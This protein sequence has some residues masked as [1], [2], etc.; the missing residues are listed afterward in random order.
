MT[1]PALLAKN[2]P[3]LQDRCEVKDQDIHLIRIELSVSMFQK[4]PKLPTRA[5]PNHAVTNAPQMLPHELAA[6]RLVALSASL[7]VQ[8]MRV[9]GSSNSANVTAW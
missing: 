6:M 4:G 8:L 9:I 7:F 1:N 5:A 2:C 3:S